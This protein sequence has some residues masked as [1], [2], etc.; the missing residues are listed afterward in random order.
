[1]YIYIYVF[2]LCGNLSCVIPYQKPSKRPEPMLY[3]CPSTDEIHPDIENMDFKMAYNT[4]LVYLFG[5]INVNERNILPPWTPFHV[6][7]SS[8]EISVSNITYNPILMAHPTN[9]DI[10]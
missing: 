4:E 9:Y 10:I 3:P 7:L 2:S 6:M 1:M 8:T 5:R